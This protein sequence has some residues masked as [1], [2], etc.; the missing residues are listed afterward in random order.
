MEKQLLR[1]TLQ[2]NFYE[3]NK[4]LIDP[5]LF[6][7]EI[8][9]I[10]DII[11]EAHAQYQTDLEVDWIRKL[12]RT[13]NPSA[14]S[15][16]RLNIMSILDD[17]DNEDDVPDNVAK[18][19]LRRMY[20][21]SVAKQ[22]ADKALDWYNGD[23]EAATS[24]RSILDTY[25]ENAPLA[26]EEEFQEVTLGL[27]ELIEQNSTEHLYPFRLPTLREE[28]YGLGPGN[29]ALVFAR[30]ETGKTAWTCYQNGGYLQH[31]LSVAHFMNEEPASKVKLRTICSTIEW[32]EAQIRANVDEAIQLFAPYNE[33]F[34]MIDCV[35]MSIEKV[36][37]WVAKHKPDVVVLD[38]LDK[39]TVQGN[40]SRPDEKL[41]AIYAYAREIAKRHKCLV[42]GVSQ[43]SADGEGLMTITYDMMAGSK[44][45]KAG[46]ADFIM[47]IGRRALVGNSD[48]ENLRQ[49]NVSKNKVG[50][51][52]H[53]H[54]MCQIIKDKA[55]YDV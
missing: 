19:I 46:E 51:C 28:C 16:R 43:C 44:T 10:Y 25:S 48:S 49:I 34:H 11:V 55:M 42:W 31:G 12:Y 20:E 36:D 3:E 18:D 8:G 39:F 5:G 4:G 47:G 17:V 45:A 52:W 38:S 41:G 40:Y 50:D 22:V 54:I 6:P 1:K 15:A 27:Q 35:G 13:S 30:P 24:I 33:K 21:S 32:T 26:Q 14:T 53:G 2:H 9:D 7:R 29:F 23:T 37:A